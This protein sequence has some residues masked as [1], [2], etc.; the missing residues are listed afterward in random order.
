MKIRT[1]AVCLATF[2]ASGAFAGVDVANKGN[3]EG[4]LCVAGPLPAVV[5]SDSEMGGSFDLIGPMITKPGMLYHAANIHCLGAWSV[6]GGQYNEN[7]H[8][9]VVDGDGDK[10]FGKFS[11]VNADGRWEVISGTGKYA[12][13]TSS[14]P[15]TPVAQFP[16]PVPGT[17]QHCNKI[18]G[19]WKLR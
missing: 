2:A 14:G 10:I 13:M 11:R 6:V 3:Y 1:L 18:T 5:Q 16:Q 17:L 8:C 19:T 15:Y 9:Q 12:G 4:M 7:G